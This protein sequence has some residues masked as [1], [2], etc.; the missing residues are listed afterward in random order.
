VSKEEA[1]AAFVEAGGP[2]W[3]AP[4]ATTLAVLASVG[5]VAYSARYYL[6]TFE[7]P[8]RTEAHHAP[9]AFAAPAALAAVAGAGFG[10]TVWVLDPVAN[11]VGIDTTGADPDLHLAVWHGLA[12]PLLLSAI[13]VGAGLGL[14]LLR[15]RVERWQARVELP[16]SGPAVYDRAYDAVLRLGALVGAP[17]RSSTPARF[18]LPILGVLVA[19]GITVGIGVDRTALGPPAEWMPADWAVIVLLAGCIVGVIQARSRLAAV[20][21]LGLAGFTVA[22]WFVL[23]GAPDL[24]LTQLLVETLTIAVVV[25]VFRRLPATFTKR[26]RSRKVG[27]GLVA[28][29][30]GLLAGGAAY[31]FTGRRPIAD[32]GERFLA[33]GEG[34]TGGGNVVNTILVD[35][36][37]LDTLGEIT[38]LAVAAAAI[39]ALIRL[40]AHGAVPRPPRAFGR[41]RSREPA[42]GWSKDHEDAWAGI[43]VIDSPILASAT[44]LLAPVMVGASLWLLVRGHDAVGGGFIG[45]LTAGSAVVLLYLSRGHQRIWQSRLLQTL[46]MV[47]I[48]LLVAVAYGLGGLALDGAF[49]AGTDVTLLFGVHVAASLVFDVGVYLVVVGI[50]VAVIRHLGQGIPEEPPDPD[51]MAPGPVPDDATGTSGTDGAPAPGPQHAD[52]APTRQVR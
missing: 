50:V 28:A 38:V 8:V 15:T 42:P 14:V 44:N 49:L 16:V 30:A 35:F 46:P 21:T 47:G 3:L 5:T 11:R 10:L 1:F 25:L 4:T 36:R 40:S 9:T 39:V 24:A 45:G 26:D 32:V 52:T 51:R 20:A 7:G 29:A 12:L 27:S 6:G 34:L 43:G 48:G 22:G 2:A 17:A 33:E 31:L 23:I 41:R 19:V 37:A 13:V 18:L